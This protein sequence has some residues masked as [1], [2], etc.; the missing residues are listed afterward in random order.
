MSKETIYVKG[1]RIFNPHEKA[2]DFVKGTVILEPK[3]LMEFFKSNSEHFTEYN[4][5][6][7]LRCQLLQGDK[8]MYLSVDTYKPE[9]QPQSQSEVDDSLPF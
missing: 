3:M 7:Q 1:V 6:K 2:P 5:E 8:G 4:G 9:N